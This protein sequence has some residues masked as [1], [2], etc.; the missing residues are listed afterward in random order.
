M[1]HQTEAWITRH[2]VS[3]ICHNICTPC[4][5]AAS[6]ACLLTCL[7]LLCYD[8]RSL[9]C[10]IDPLA[11]VVGVKAPQMQQMMAECGLFDETTL[12]PTKLSRIFVASGV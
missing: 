1:A 6:V 11:H 12:T 9:Y 4:L 10:S 2:A 7:H 3:A 8:D 5:G